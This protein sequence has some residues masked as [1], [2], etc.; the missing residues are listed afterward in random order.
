MAHV[1]AAGATQL[2]AG[3]PKVPLLQTA[4]I[5]PVQGPG[6][7]AVL[8]SPLFVPDKDTTPHREVTL[9]VAHAAPTG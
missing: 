7:L 2:S 5:V 4:L 9:A 8:V 3:V 1:A 6:Q